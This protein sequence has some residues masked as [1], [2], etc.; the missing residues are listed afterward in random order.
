MTYRYYYCLVAALMMAATV[1]RASNLDP[2]CLPGTLQAYENMSDTDPGGCSIGI[3]NFSNFT[4]TASEG[5]SYN[6]SDI[7][8]TPAIGG[9]TFSLVTTLGFPTCEDGVVCFQ[10]PPG[11]NAIYDAGYTFYI[12]PGPMVGNASL[13]MD[14]PFGNV[15]INQYYCADTG[16]QQFSVGQMPT[17]T[18]GDNP[19]VLSVND[20]NPPA[21][22][23]TGLV[24]L[25]PP[26]T[27]YA[28]VLTMINLDGPAGFDSVT[29]DSFVMNAAPEPAT[30]LAVT[31]GFL[32]LALRRK[33]LLS[34]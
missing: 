28:N 10:A 14:P 33:S 5:A 17:C 16:L 32:A 21:S 23:T 25:S 18:N 15:M 26:V 6:A 24:P 30:L 29:G 27:T 2:V 4:F 11:Q 34:L 8:L 22:W 13:G 7:E 9:F 20:N 12:D 19:T 3:L 31:V 1:A